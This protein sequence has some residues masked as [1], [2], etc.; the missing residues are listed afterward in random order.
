MATEQELL[1]SLCSLEFKK[2]KTS[3]MLS[4]GIFWWGLL[5][6]FLWQGKTKS[7]PSPWTWNWSL[8]T[9]NH[10]IFGFALK[11]YLMSTI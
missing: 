9:M 4:S 3:S 10:D 6:L 7:T 1:S 8:T 11:F 5:L 2:F